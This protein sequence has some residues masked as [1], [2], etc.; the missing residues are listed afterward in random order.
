MVSLKLSPEV[1]L[2]EKFQCIVTTY[3]KFYSDIW[4]PDVCYY[5]KDKHLIIIDG[6]FMEKQGG[7]KGKVQVQITK[8]LNPKKNNPLGEI[9]VTTFERGGTLAQSAYD[10]KKDFAIDRFA[11]T[12]RMEC[13]YP[14]KYC[15]KSKDYCT[16]CW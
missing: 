1:V 13:T 12:P 10:P 5:D 15:G 7:Y 6:V 9:E 14:C 2:D 11:F 4:A 8:I 16:A 3:K